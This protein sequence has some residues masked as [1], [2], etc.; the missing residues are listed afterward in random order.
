MEHQR[1]LLINYKLLIMQYSPVYC[2]SPLGPRILGTQSLNICIHVGFEV[3]RAVVMK[4]YIFRNMTPCSLLEI[5]RRL[6]GICRFRLHGRRID[7]I[8]D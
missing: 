8:K 6:G 7:Q 3:L 2:Y 5:N 4:S 1:H